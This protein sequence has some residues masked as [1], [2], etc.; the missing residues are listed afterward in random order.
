VIV[1]VG[2]GVGLTGVGVLAGVGDDVAR[3]VGVGV[4]RR[5]ALICVAALVN[6]TRLAMTPRIKIKRSRFILRLPC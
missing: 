4:A 6:P 3:R 5:W 1:G 2:V